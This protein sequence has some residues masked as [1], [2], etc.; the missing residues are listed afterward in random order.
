MRIDDPAGGPPWALKVFD[1]ER[2]TLQR[3]ARTLAKGRIVGRNRCVQ[4]GRLRR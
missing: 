3:P 1:A 2:I 4:L